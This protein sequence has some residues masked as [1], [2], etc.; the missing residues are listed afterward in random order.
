M[1]AGLNGHHVL[2]PETVMTM[3]ENHIGELN[4]MP[5]KTALP[6]YSN[7]V[8]LY[9]DQDKKWGLSFLI[10]TRKTAEG[11][12]AG[13]LAWAGLANTYFWLDPTAQVAGVFLMQFLPFA[14][15]KALDLFASFER[16]VYGGIE[17]TRQAA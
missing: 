5:L 4:V 13:S 16:G 12:S 14:D 17:G 1:A 10:N 2:K 8:E 11:R 3:A 7:D 6:Q 15:T 9:P